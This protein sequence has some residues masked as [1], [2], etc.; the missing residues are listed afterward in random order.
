MTLTEKLRAAIP[1]RKTDVRIRTLHPE[2]KMVD[3]SKGIVDYVASDETLDCYREVVR[4]NG[5][6]FTHFS[7]N[8]PFVDSHDY[9]TIGKQLG[10]V[11]DFRVE[12]DQLIERV[13]WAIDVKENSLAQLGWKMT[14]AGY[15]KAV[16]VGFS[17][18]RYVTKWDADPKTWRDQLEQIGMHEEDGVRCIYVEQ[19]QL[20]LSACILGANPNALAKA[21]K[22]GAIGDAELETFSQE[23]AKQET[24][25]VADEPADAAR[26]RQRGLQLRIREKLNQLTKSI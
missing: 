24:A 6:K 23:F 10:R 17:P 22:T 20:E 15:L 16:S 2:V 21:Y 11:I 19:E 1:Q 14:E 8:A 18:T 26:A 5:W 3:A 4:A 12:K 13:Q 9:F 25:R 7:K